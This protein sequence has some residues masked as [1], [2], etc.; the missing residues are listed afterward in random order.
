MESIAC[1]DNDWLYRISD[2]ANVEYFGGHRTYRT[3]MIYDV[4]GHEC[5]RL[6]MEQKEP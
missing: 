3:C 5:D 4:E 6:Y 1:W 2:G